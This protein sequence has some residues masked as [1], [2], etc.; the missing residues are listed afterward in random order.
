[1][2]CVFGVLFKKFFT[3]SHKIIPLHLKKKIVV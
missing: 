2:I 1:M 3:S